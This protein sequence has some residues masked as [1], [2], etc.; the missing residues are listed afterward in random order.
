M[1][2][3]REDLVGEWDGG[4]DFSLRFNEDGTFETSF[5]LGTGDT[6]STGLETKDLYS[7]AASATGADGGSIRVKMSLL[8][9]AFSPRGK[10]ADWHN[11]T[12]DITGKW[13]IRGSRLYLSPFEGQVTK[14]SGEVLGAK[15]RKPRSL[16]VDLELSQDVLTA[17]LA[18]GKWKGSEIELTRQ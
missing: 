10:G 8:D 6:T 7:L 5:I 17:A 4:G 2:L 9:L 3:I 18:D 14:R 15:N 11:S 13:R 16:I 12:V 1:A